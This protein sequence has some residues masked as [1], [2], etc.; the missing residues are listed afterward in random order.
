M[1]K[2]KVLNKKQLQKQ[3]KKKQQKNLLKKENLPKVSLCTPTFNRRPFFKQTIQNVLNQ[4][5]PLDK[6][7]WVIIDDGTDKI[8]D[9][10]ND[11]SGI[12]IKYIELEE[13]ISLGK[14]RNM[15]HKESTGDIIIYIDD[16]DYYPP[17]RVHH[18]VTELLKS[19]KL[20][21]GSSEL[22]VWFEKNGI[23]KFGPYGI[24]HSTAGTFAFKRE[25]LNSTQYEDDKCFAEE[26][27]FLQDYSIPLIQLDPFKT[28]MVF[29][30]PHNTIDKLQFIKK[31]GKFVKSTK[32]DI[33]KFIQDKN[34]VQ[35]Y[36]KDIFQAL[37][38][39]Q[40]GT[41]D[42]KPDLIK[43]LEERE[44]SLQQNN[45]QNNKLYS[46]N[47]KGERKEISTQELLQLFNNEK[48]INKEKTETI[49]MLQE[50]LLEQNKIIE[51][52]KNN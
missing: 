33:D 2:K 52:Y 6:I 19:K 39:Y 3:E 44:K 31:P 13:K 41:R 40:Y 1:R 35:F 47:G 38:D 16:D 46:T 34:A 20:I 45:S 11:I 42:N 36:T 29:N 28:I 27:K 37:T 8:Q 22:Y 12:N 49:K 48:K 32:Y 17:E 23:W 7:E 25:L 26:K 43:A 14:K 24:N 21:A 9:I 50:K 5:Y 51:Q 30:H 10:I 15:L 4:T 18:A